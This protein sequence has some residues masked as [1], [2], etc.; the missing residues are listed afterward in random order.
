MGETESTARQIG[1]ILRDDECMCWHTFSELD[2]GF[3]MEAFD[4]AILDGTTG[5]SS[6]LSILIK[7][8]CHKLKPVLVLVGNI[9]AREENC[10]WGMGVTD[11]MKVPFTKDECRKKIDSTYRWKWYYGR[12]ECHNTEYTH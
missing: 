1:E 2:D 6:A 11:V 9:S 4:V 7:L 10:I 3:E 12:H 8:N 5:Q